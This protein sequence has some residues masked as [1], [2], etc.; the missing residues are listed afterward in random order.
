MRERI[1]LI[2]AGVI[3][4]RHLQAM[5]GCESVE[6]V[7]IVDPKPFTLDLAVY[8]G[9]PRFMDA[10]SMLDAVAPTGVL[11]ATPTDSHCEPALM[12]LHRGCHLLIEKPLTA[13]LEE[14]RRIS[15]LAEEKGLHVLVG[16]HRRY[17]PQ[18]EKARDLVRGGALGKPVAVSG[19]WCV[20]KHDSYYDS[21]WRR[22]WQGGPVMT[23]LV[24]EIDC[25]RYIIGPVVSVQAESGNEFLGMDK[26]DTV[27]L[28]M[29]FTGGVLGT[30]VLSDRADSP[31]AWEFATG[32]NLAFPRSA[33]NCMRFAGTR[34][35]LD[36]PNLRL[37]T[38][39]G[40]PESWHSPKTPRDLSI[41]PVDAFVRQIGHFADVIAGRATPRITATDAT[42][43]LQTTL[44]VLEAAKTGAR[45][46]L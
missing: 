33:Q 22:R 16:H 13:T 11:I 46:V 41:E 31:W 38:S 7:A 39:D 23:N 44:A 24:H 29:R 40:A 32:E 43:S 37:W 12:A 19:Q 8:R 34:A 10:G 21:E 36:F 5:T 42:L 17:Y 15:S 45:V 27:A 1:A 26:E 2:G 28:I 6:L 9:V 3:G 14:A 18:V 25:L 35:A 30:F 4:R 20:R